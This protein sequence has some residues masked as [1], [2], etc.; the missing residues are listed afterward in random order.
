[1]K[2]GKQ[3][4]RLTRAQR[5]KRSHRKILNLQRLPP[6]S[7]TSLRNQFLMSMVIDIESTFGQKFI[8]RLFQRPAQ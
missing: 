4:N 6:K 1:M 8:M 2:N 5:T 7:G 3:R